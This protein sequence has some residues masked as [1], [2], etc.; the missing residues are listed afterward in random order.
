MKG[1]TVIGLVLLAA[2]ILLWLVTPRNVTWGDHH[3]LKHWL[4]YGL[5][6]L[7]ALFTIVGVRRG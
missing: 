4:S 5:I 1:P 3:Y 7:G 2:G 6:G